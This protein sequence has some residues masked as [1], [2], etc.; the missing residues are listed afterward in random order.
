MTPKTVSSFYG[1]ELDKKLPLLQLHS[2][3]SQESFSA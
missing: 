3:Y 1:C 2:E